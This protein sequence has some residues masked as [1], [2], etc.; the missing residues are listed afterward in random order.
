MNPH[1]EFLL[2]S[3]MI[4]TSIAAP[5]VAIQT[6]QAQQAIQNLPP[7]YPYPAKSVFPIT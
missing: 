5:F 7:R 2:S 4:L 1:R 6:V 3:A